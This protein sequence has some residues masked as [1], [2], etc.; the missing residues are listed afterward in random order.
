MQVMDFFNQMQTSH[1]HADLKSS[2]PHYLFVHSSLL[3]FVLTINA[4]V[5]LR[6]TLCHIEMI[7]RMFS[8]SNSLTK[9]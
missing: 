4:S 8:W 6:Y 7:E 3:S 1:I 9:K 2:R 5:L